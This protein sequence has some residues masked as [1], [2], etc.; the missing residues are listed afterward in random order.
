MPLPISLLTVGA[1]S[2]VSSALALILPETLSKVL[3]D[4]AADMKNDAIN[5]ITINH[6]NEDTDIK[7]TRESDLA[8]RQILREKLFS[9]DWVDAG[10]GILVN[11]T[12]NK[13][14]E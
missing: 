2:L 8:Q 5:D 11:F 12:E 13:S 1:M 10:N 9:E 3:P 7:N 4:R 14:T 6:K